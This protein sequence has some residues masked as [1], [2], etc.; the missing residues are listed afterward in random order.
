MSV[1]VQFVFVFELAH[2][3]K[4]FENKNDSLAFKLASLE[5]NE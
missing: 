5:N 1:H 3:V 4:T 2:R